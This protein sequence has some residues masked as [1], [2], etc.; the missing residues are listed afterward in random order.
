MF[1]REITM[2]TPVRR[3]F[4][5]A[6]EALSAYALTHGNLRVPVPIHELAQWIG[7]RKNL[8][9]A[10]DEECL[11]LVS[12]RGRV[13]Q[14]SGVRCWREQR[15]ALARDVARILL[16]HPTPAECPPWEIVCLEAEA[17]ECAGELLVPEELLR[18]WAR[19]TTDVKVLARMFDVNEEMIARRIT[20]VS[21]I[22]AARSVATMQTGPAAGVDEHLATTLE[23][24]VAATNDRE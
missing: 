6:H 15:H 19:S 22:Q 21:G 1:D 12:D 20:T 23:H 16:H 11:A 24:R 17:E 10:T 3:G 8:L 7:L 4:A 9:N 5:V 13:V 14:W 18:R 2:E